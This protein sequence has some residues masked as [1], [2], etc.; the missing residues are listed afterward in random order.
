MECCHATGVRPVGQPGN[1][2]PRAIDRRDDI[3]KAPPAVRSSSTFWALHQQGLKA[4]QWKGS[5]HF[6]SGRKVTSD[7][8]GHLRVER[9]DFVTQK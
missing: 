6:V 7:G 8:N 5:Q 1:N 3:T 9:C 2:L 4:P